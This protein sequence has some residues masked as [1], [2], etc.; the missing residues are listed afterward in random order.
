MNSL[1]L[2]KQLYPLPLTSVNGTLFPLFFLAFFTTKSAQAAELKVCKTCDFKTVTSAVKAAKPHDRI[3]VQP[4]YYAES[5]I[6]IKKPLQLIGVGK[7]V[8][9]A[10]NKGGIFQVE[11]RNVLIKGFELRNVEVSYLRDF[12]AIKVYEGA[13]VTISDNLIKNAFFGIY[14]Q[15]TDSCTVARNV[16]E[17]Q[18]RTETTSGNAIHLWYSDFITI[19]DNKTSGH[20]DG[21]YLEFAKRSTIKDNLSFG[22]IRYG[23]HFMFSDGNVYT[24]NTFRNN[25][26]GVAVMYT[27]DIVMQH[28]TFEHN[29]GPAAYGLLLKDI[30]RSTI[31]NN[32]FIKNTAGIYMEGSTYLHIEKNTFQGNG[33]A[34]RVI[35]SCSEDTF[36]LNNFMSNTF[37]VSTN[38]SSAS[39]YFS[40][41]YW[42]K[43]EGYDL[44]KDRIGDVPYRP[45]SL[46][47]LVVERVP[48]SIMFLRSFIVDLM[49]R[50]EKVIPS[51]TPEM[52]KD[53][54]PVLRQ[55]AYDHA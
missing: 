13:H 33:W 10:K 48:S 37:D 11:T 28:N 3:L 44:N 36:R 9:D 7:P 5:N 17:G 29:W 47:S 41:N 54:S 22:N 1:K 27:R 45:V 2:L 15:R 32:R 25:G 20:R 53:D 55:H 26:A 51:F 46:Y 31:S 42:D 24:H 38:A 23:L 40:H 39:N 43:Y 6:E 8:I 19:T 14:L 50:M 18:A 4:G 30:S 35:S 34:L 52:L 21:I 49:D 16:V 12:A